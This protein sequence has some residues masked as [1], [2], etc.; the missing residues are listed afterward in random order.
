MSAPDPHR[1]VT[2]RR[3][4]IAQEPRPAKAAPSAPVRE[5]DD[6]WRVYRPEW[7]VVGAARN[8]PEAEVT[9]DFMFREYEGRVRPE[10][11]RRVVVG[12][13]RQL[14]LRLPNM[15]GEFKTK[16]RAEAYVR[17]EGWTDTT[18]VVRNS[19]Q[20]HKLRSYGTRRLPK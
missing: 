9:L 12:D 10:D 6:L 5:T 17:A 7:M 2:D 13:V 14:Q 20:D 19:A 16:G 8:V 3:D 15:R 1:A 4:Q 18:I 11:V